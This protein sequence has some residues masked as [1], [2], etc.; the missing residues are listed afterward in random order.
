MGFKDAYVLFI[1][2]KTC[3][4]LMGNVKGV[5]YI[6]TYDIVYL[7]SIAQTV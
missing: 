5:K 2:A 6:Y 4:A 7:L 3:I 1:L